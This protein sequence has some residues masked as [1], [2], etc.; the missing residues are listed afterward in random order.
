MQHAAAACTVAGPA[1]STTAAGAATRHFHYWFIIGPPKSR[2][3]ILDVS[4]VEMRGS[5]FLAG[6]IVLPVFAAP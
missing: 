3:E 4:R 6:L 5:I 1:A 2:E